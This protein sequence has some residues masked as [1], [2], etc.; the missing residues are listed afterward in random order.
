MIMEAE[1]ELSRVAIILREG[2]DVAVAKQKIPGGTALSFDGSA[3]RLLADVPAGH[4]FALRA[5]GDGQPVH[6]FGQIIGYATADIR[7]GEWVHTRNL[8]FGKGH[9]EGSGALALDYEFCTDV[10]RVDYVPE[11]QRRT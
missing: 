5:I 6:K 10:P 2:D 8:G 4:K 3:V 7:P 11:A 9:V 1:Q